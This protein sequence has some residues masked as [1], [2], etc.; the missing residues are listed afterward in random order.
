MEEQKKKIAE[1]LYLKNN[2][3]PAA[4][5]SADATK[6]DKKAA[7]KQAKADKKAAKKQQFVGK[8]RLA[9][10]GKI[11][12]SRKI[13]GDD[14][15]KI[16]W[17][18]G[19]TKGSSAT[20]E[21]TSE[22]NI[23]G[24]VGGEYGVENVW[25]VKAE[26]TYTYKHTSR[27]A[28]TKSYEVNT[29]KTTEEQYIY[30]GNMRV[31]V[32][33]PYATL[34][35]GRRWFFPEVI[36]YRDTETLT[37]EE[38]VQKWE[39]DAQEVKLEFY[40]EIVETVIDFVQDNDIVNIRSSDGWWLSNG[41]SNQ[42]TYCAMAT[43]DNKAK[44]RFRVHFNECKDTGVTFRPDQ[45]RFGIQLELLDDNNYFEG[46]TYLYQATTGSTKYDYHHTKNSKQFWQLDYDNKNPNGLTY[47][48]EH[49]LLDMYTQ[50][51]MC[52]NTTAQVKWNGWAWSARRCNPER[53]WVEGKYSRHLKKNFDYKFFF[54][55]DD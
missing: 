11:H 35:N 51:H 46:C 5:A 7:K 9:L 23:A 41:Y 55:R 44:A 2:P 31:G 26:V 45:S 40:T 43:K 4:A 52:V 18:E 27:Q 3:A 37:V 13:P 33:Q 14:N 15:I 12:D 54:F 38:Q 39:D 48:Q 29:L 21:T 17:Q 16:I 25:K 6:A 47:G 24:T 10:L 28:G 53:N 32:Y 50:S 1:Y 19:I 36:K 8:P 49:V 34:N 42:N 30:P 22:H 20:D